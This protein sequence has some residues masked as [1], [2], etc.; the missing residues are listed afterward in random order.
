MYP[1]PYEKRSR[2]QLIYQS[3]PGKGVSPEQLTVSQTSLC[4]MCTG[5]ATSFASHQHTVRKPKKGPNLFDI[6]QAVLNV[7]DT[8][9][10]EILVNRGSD[11]SLSNRKV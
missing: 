10:D 7:A 8:H 4:F 2:G 5:T 1:G 3:H 6:D 11:R 9:V